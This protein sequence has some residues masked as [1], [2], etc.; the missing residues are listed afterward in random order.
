MVALGGEKVHRLALARALIRRTKVCTYPIL[1]Q[2]EFCID[3]LLVRVH[4]I[5]VMMKWIG[6]AP[7]E[8]ESLFQVALHLPS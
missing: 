4:F 3:D 2:S 8:V 6:L 5:I 1:H 7:W